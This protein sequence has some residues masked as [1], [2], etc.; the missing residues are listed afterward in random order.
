MYFRTLEHVRHFWRVY[1]VGCWRYLSFDKWF[2]HFHYSKIMEKGVRTLNVWTISR[3]FCST[4]GLLLFFMKGKVGETSSFRCGKTLSL[5]KK[6]QS[7]A[8]FYAFSLSRYSSKKHLEGE[9]LKIIENFLFNLNM[10][11]KVMIRPLYQCSNVLVCL[12]T[13]IGGLLDLWAWDWIL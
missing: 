7:R 8:M 12:M 2:R 1:L 10:S 5:L 6:Q 13:G 11:Q 3:F 4:L 9:K